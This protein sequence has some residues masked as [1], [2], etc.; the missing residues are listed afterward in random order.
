MASFPCGFIL[1]GSVPGLLRTGW[2]FDAAHRGRSRMNLG[3]KKKKF[4]ELM[5]HANP[6]VKE[7]K[8]AT[9]QISGG[10]HILEGI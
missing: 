1:P 4:F 3:E 6:G 9:S 7:K 10:D 5:K 8:Q 2:A